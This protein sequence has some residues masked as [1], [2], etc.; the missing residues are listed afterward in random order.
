VASF[1][2]QDKLALFG[3]K[4]K[5]ATDFSRPKP[6]QDALGNK[7]LDPEEELRLIER[8]LMEVKVAFDQFFL[9]FERKS[10]LRRRDVLGERIRKFRSHLD[11][12]TPAGFRFRLDQAQAKF[13]AYDRIWNR[14]LQ[15]KEAGRD[16]RD[17]FKMKMKQKKAGEETMPPAPKAAAPKP[18]PSA[19]TPGQLKTLYDTFVI[20]RQRTNEPTSG[21]SMET[22]GKTLEKQ[23][24]ALLK[25]FNCEAVDFKVVIKNNKAVLKAVP[26]K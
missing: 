13:A 10:P 16:S 24:P 6:K 2:D 20:A 14:N 15:D 18:P 26:R 11:A 9:G 21:L 8:E 3:G 7:I 23:V 1:R 17:L 4:P 22:L 12:K 25:Q 5:D 19:L